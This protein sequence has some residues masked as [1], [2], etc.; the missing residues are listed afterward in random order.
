MLGTLTFNAENWWWVVLLSGLLLL[1]ISYFAWKSEGRLVKGYIWGFILRALGIVLL[2]LCLLDPHWTGERP[3]KGANIVAVVADNSQGLQL[4]DSNQTESRGQLLKDKLAGAE[5]DWLATLGEDYQTR[6]YRFDR[7]L[8]RVTDFGS[9]DFSGDRSNLSQ[10]LTQ[11]NER[12]DGLPLGGILLFT[13]GIATDSDAIETLNLDNLPPIYPV[14]VGD[15]EPLPDLSIDRIDIRQT[16]FDDAPVS[17]SVSLSSNAL[18]TQS[19]RVAITPIQIEGDISL[20]ED[21]PDTPRPQTIRTRSEGSNH[22][23]AFDWR[24]AKTGIQFFDVSTEPAQGVE[25]EATKSNNRRLFMVDGGQE[26]FRIL[27]VTGRPNWEYKF[28]NRALY[29]D[30]QLQM[31]GLIRVARREPKFEF[32]GRAGESSNPLYRGF[33]KADEEAEEYDQPV[34]IRVNTRNAEELADGFPDDAE[35]L[36]EYDALILD[37]LEADFFSFNQQTLIR[38]FVSERGGGLLALGGADALDHGGYDDTPIAATLPIYLDKQFQRANSENLQ[39]KL[40][41]EGWVEPWTRVRSIETEEQ[42]R[43]NEM[44]PFSV[45]NTIPRIKPG[46][47]VL[48]EVENLLG[49][50]YPSLIA[51]NFGSGKVACVAVGDLWR[52]GMRGPAEQEDLAKLW[53]QIARWLVTDVA[54]PVEIEA[55]QNGEGVELIVEARDEA[56]KALEIGRARISI[57]RVDLDPAEMA[58]YTG[59]KEVDL[60]ADPVTNASGR[61]AANFSSTDEG[62][63]IAKVEVLGPE[64]EVV[65]TA[66]TGWVN[67][68][69]ANE[70]QSLLPQTDLLESIAAK[71]KGR[72]IRWDELDSLTEL[73]DKRS[74]PIT[75]TWSY[76]LW[77]NGWLFIAALS[78]FLAEWALRRKR[79]LA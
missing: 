40:T 22:S 36:F 79:G 39:W 59:F 53:R 24:P 28:L 56:Y 70:F 2:L 32:K 44:P 29:D 49:D 64:G 3:A 57:Q 4:I 15:S 78:C 37:D 1:P 16:A 71:T 12:F 48:A 50:R 17:L 72:I 5:A 76:P 69:L 67:E 77:H 19:A 9:L 75:E 74:A 55:H 20:I 63:Y 51:H 35:E 6:S 60:Y 54:M 38:R 34:L 11:L 61:F 30:H 21:D 26:V 31:S 52:W 65:G 45:L 41:R 18:P 14:I 47:R 73:F 68:P 58:N 10:A 62:A 66:E 23:L 33:D 27:Y 25:Q 7:D 43:L 13:D 8:R 46:A 42:V